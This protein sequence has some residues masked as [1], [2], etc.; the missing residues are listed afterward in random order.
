MKTQKFAIEVGDLL[1]YEGTLIYCDEIRR[2]ERKR[3]YHFSNPYIGKVAL[4]R[5]EVILNC[6][7]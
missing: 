5:S 3:V 4:T 6:H 2:Y 7:K 1:F